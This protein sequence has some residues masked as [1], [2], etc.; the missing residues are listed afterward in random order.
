[1]SDNRIVVSVQVSL[2]GR[3]A[4]SGGELDWFVVQDELHEHFVTEH[5]K[6]GMFLYG[7]RTYEGMAGY[8]PTADEDPANDQWLVK[9]SKLWKS[10]PKA[11]FSKTM[12]YAEW[13]TTVLPDLESL[14]GP[15]ERT[16]GDLYLVGSG[17]VITE[18]AR[19]DLIDEYQLY[20]HPV[21]LGAGPSLLE[22]ISK[23]QGLTLA[24]TQTFDHAVVKLTYRRIR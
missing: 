3:T 10:M 8:W 2:D 16:S 20:V 13:D 1:M 24:D 4:G 22:D 5:S 23:R 18:F 14:A 12:Q 9:Y 6:A 21:A 15:R 19:H 17:E 7:R 11:V